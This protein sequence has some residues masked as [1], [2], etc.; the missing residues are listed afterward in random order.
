MPVFFPISI[1]KIRIASN[2]VPAADEG[3]QVLGV[4]SVLLMVKTLTCPA[5]SGTHWVLAVR[6][7]GTSTT[8]PAPAVVASASSETEQV[9]MNRQCPAMLSFKNG[10]ALRCL[11]TVLLT[12]T[13]SKTNSDSLLPNSKLTQL[14]LRHAASLTVD[15]CRGVVVRLAGV[16]ATVASHRV[17]VRALLVAS[18]ERRPPQL[19]QP[20]TSSDVN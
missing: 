9:S 15:V 19:P 13:S 12:N 1:V 4:L 11:S 7:L 8:S 2:S 6:V 10:A 16:V 3:L 17:R 18:P 20:R 14:L 5:S